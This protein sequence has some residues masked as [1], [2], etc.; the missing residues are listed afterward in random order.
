MFEYQGWATIREACNE[1]DEND[2]KL[3]LAVKK[4]GQQVKLIDHGHRVIGLRPLNGSY[5]LWT[6]GF[7]NHKGSDWFEVY[8]LFKY[9]AKNTVGSYG[10]LSCWDDENTDGEH[11]E[12]Q[13][14]AL[15]RGELIKHKDPFLSP[16]FPTIVDGWC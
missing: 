2:A 10:I 8:N 9:A 5:R 7:A 11:N 6:I 1:E 13:I 12:M 3:E 15:K 4:I 16:C 14:Y